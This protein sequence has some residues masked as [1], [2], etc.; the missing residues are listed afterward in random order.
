LKSFR[1]K[2]TCLIVI[3]LFLLVPVSV[4][5]VSAQSEDRVP[6]VIGFKEVPDDALVRSHGGEIKYVYRYIAAIAASVPS[7]AID[8]LQ[9]NPKVVYVEY[10]FEVYVTAQTVPWGVAKIGSPDVWAVG[11]KGTNVKVAILDTGIDITHPDLKVV[12]GATYV[13]GTTTY[14][15]DHGHG[16]HVAGIVGAL[17]NTVGVVGV[18]PEAALYAVKVLDKNGRGYISSINMGIEWSIS[19]RMQVISM[20]FGSTSDSISLHQECDEAYNFGIVLV[21]AAGNNGPGAETMTYPAKYSSVIAVGATDSNDIVSDWS[22]RGQEMWVTAPGVSIYSTYKG[23]TYVTMSGTSMACPHVTGTTALILAKNPTVSPDDVKSILQK[24]AVK[25]G[26]MNGWYWTSA[27]GFG[28]VDAY[29]AVSAA[30]TLPPDFSLSASPS[31]LEIQQGGYGTST[32]TVTSQNGFSSAVTL[33]FS[34]NPTGVTDSFSTNPVTPPSGGSATSAL[35]INVD[36]ST[37]TGTYTLT[38]T[39]V[40]GSLTHSATLTLTVTSPPTTALSVKVTTDNPTYTRKS[41]AVITVTVTAN[42]NPASGASVTITVIDPKGRTMEDFGTTDADGR[43]TFR[44]RIVP[45]APL[46]TYS[47]I[48]QAFAAGF[49]PGTG[50]TTFIVVK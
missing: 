44:Y 21:A 46:G 11:N 39:G 25:T 9:K 20:S 19:N 43:V 14:N 32:I 48:I 34:G 35:T 2:L 7:Q 10:D 45:N 47:V 28:R 13:F 17:Y 27:Y 36:S 24:T 30:Q 23:G 49:N 15:D 4:L 50:L 26:G 12:G 42:S 1:I 38:V 18:A 41:F 22:S 40:S 37:S 16:T 3:L 33:S 6:V 5:T 29:A 31:S 8:A